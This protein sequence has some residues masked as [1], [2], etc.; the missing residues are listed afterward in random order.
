MPAAALRAVR[1][2]RTLRAFE[3]RH[4]GWLHSIEDRDLVCEIGYHQCLRRPLTLT[5]IYALGHGS[6]ATMQRRLRRLRRDGCIERQ[7]SPSDRRSVVLS[8]SPGVIE[9]L[10]R[11]AELLETMPS[12]AVL[13]S[14]RRR[15]QG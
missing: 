3:R 12:R 2:L 1:K 15:A 8:L 13:R 4:L 7:C 5:Q 9:A 6:I 10:A 11:Y 14:P